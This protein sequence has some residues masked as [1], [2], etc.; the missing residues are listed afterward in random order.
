[1]GRAPP[2]TGGTLSG[3][4]SLTANAELTGHAILTVTEADTAI[5]QRSGDVPVLA[6]PR[7]I[8]LL[9]EAAVAALAG[10]L[11][12][13]LTSVGV[14]VSVDHLAPS[15]IGATVRATAVLEAIADEALEFA[16]EAVDGET[17]V[18]VGGHTRVIVE[19]DR[20][21]ARFR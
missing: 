6:T 2:P 12:N 9:E 4:D 3:M 13:D 15:A 19:R 14:N 21:L 17:I 8:A 10:K 20:F 7:L 18:A 16:V 1:M 5:A 11:P